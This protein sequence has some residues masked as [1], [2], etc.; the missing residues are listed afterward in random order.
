MISVNHAKLVSGDYGYELEFAPFLSGDA[1]DE[2]YLELGW[3]KI[4]VN[5][6][7][8]VDENRFNVVQSG[9]KETAKLLS[10]TWS[11]A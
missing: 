11:I 6:P 5:K 1:S 3:K 7:K 4:V 2:D 10:A 8:D 9:Y